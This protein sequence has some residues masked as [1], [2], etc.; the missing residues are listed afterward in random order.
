MLL[1]CAPQDRWAPSEREHYDVFVEGERVAV[2][3]LVY[4]VAVKWLLKNQHF[5]GMWCDNPAE[6][7][8]EHCRMVHRRPGC[9]Q[10]SVAGLTACGASVRLAL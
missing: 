4:N 7:E 6:H 8:F 9:L 5:S 10:T 2:S 3:S 1:P